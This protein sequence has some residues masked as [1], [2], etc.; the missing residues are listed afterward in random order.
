MRSVQ[1]SGSLHTGTQAPG[2]SYRAVPPLSHMWV[3]M[4]LKSPRGSDERRG[5]GLIKSYYPFLSSLHPLYCP[6]QSPPAMQL[7]GAQRD[8]THLR[9]WG[10]LGQDQQDFGCHPA[11]GCG[12]Q[13]C[14]ASPRSGSSPVVFC[15]NLL[16]VTTP[17]WGTSLCN[18]FMKHDSLSDWHSWTNSSLSA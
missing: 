3:W 10:C 11:E 17:G 6:G 4:L 15:G 5:G 18:L 8:V 7:Q 16:W 13:V 2:G 1:S 14:F 12:L 9:I